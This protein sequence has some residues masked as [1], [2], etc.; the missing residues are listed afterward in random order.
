MRWG[1]S[2][3]RN[4]IG[5]VSNLDGDL[6]YS[7]WQTL[8]NCRFSVRLA[9]DG[10]D[11]FTLGVIDKRGLNPQAGAETRRVCGQLNHNN[12]NVHRNSHTDYP[13]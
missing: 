7:Q 8:E 9:A 6:V 5:K 1:S 4:G 10:D 13:C 11:I 2:V 3:C 12:N